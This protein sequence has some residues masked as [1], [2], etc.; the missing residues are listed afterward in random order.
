MVCCRRC[1]RMEDFD[2]RI[3]RLEKR[4]GSQ[5]DYRALTEQQRAFLLSFDIM[6]KTDGCSWETVTVTGIEQG[7]EGTT[8]DVRD[9]YFYLFHRNSP[10][11]NLGY[12]LERIADYEKALGIT[13]SPGAGSKRTFKLSNGSQVRVLFRAEKDR[14]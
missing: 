5:H 3:K 8:L 1:F 4:Y 11:G 7:E 6:N 2:E 12:A 14:V 13:E 9:V 10:G